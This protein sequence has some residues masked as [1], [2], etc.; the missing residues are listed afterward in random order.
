MATVTNRAPQKELFGHPVG[1]YILFFTEMWERFSY[2]GMRAILVLYLVSATTGG[3]AGLGWTGGEAIAL[4]GWY[5]ML[6]Y[7][8]SIPGGIIADKLL[9]QKKTVLWGG[10]IL[11]AGH[12]I[13]AVEEMWAFYSGLALIIIGVGMLKPNIST[14]VGGLYKPGDI[15]RDKG[16]TIFYIGINLGAF[17]SSL[18]VGYV[19]ENIGWHYGFGLAGIAMAFGL[20]VYLWGQKY[21]LNV[22]NL[23][24]KVE[25]SEGASLSNMF[26]ELL[27]SPLQLAI[28]SILMIGSIYV[29]IMMSVPFGLLYIFLTLVIALM[30]MV[31]KDLTTQVMKDR[32]VVMILSFLLVVVFWGAFEQAGGLMN[33]YAADK[34]DRTLSF[35]LPLI[36]NEVPATWF[37]S[38]NAMFIIIFGVIVA[39]FWA[40]RKLKNKEASSIFK[41]ATGVIIM[42]LGFLFMAIAAK[43]YTAFESKSAMYWLVLAYLLHTIG[44]LC[45]SPVALSFI[46]KLAPVKYASLMM[47]VYFAATGL[48][49]K[50]AGL[51]GEFSQGEPATVQLSTEGSD[52]ANR[53]QLN[54]TILQNKND[55]TFNGFVYLDNNELAVTNMETKAP[56]LG[57]MNFENK[58]QKSEIIANLKEEGVTAQDPYHVM[59]N[60]RQEEDKVGYYGDFVIEEVQTQLEFRTFIGITIF[61]TVFGLIVIFMLKPLKRLTHGAEDNEREM[62]EQEQYEIADTERDKKNS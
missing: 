44:E 18:I 21:L 50:M 35:S 33:I 9:G 7:V 19:G 2:Y 5:T 54:D 3:N 12:G 32:Y 1:L 39:N 4:Y 30:L 58:D 10:I 42:G 14:M 49:N 23:L 38:L 57:L 45:S 47:G 59:L 61:T 15:R 40:K 11:V 36:G 17:L 51:I 24:S 37:Q 16:F 48:G 29:L 46:T 22:G 43:E 53:L 8:A 34:T 20:I 26:S 56:V 52:V 60:F 6:V 13:L 41:M 31:Y 28:T 27:K 55:F 25:R 62:L